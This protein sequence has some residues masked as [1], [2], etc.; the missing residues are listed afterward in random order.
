MVWPHTKPICSSRSVVEDVF[1]TW[2]ASLV[3]CLQTTN[4]MVPIQWFLS[5]Q[6]Q[7][8]WLKFVLMLLL[9]LKHPPNSFLLHLCSYV[10]WIV[11]QLAG[12]I[13]SCHVLEL[14][15]FRVF[16][17]LCPNIQL[18]TRTRN[19]GCNIYG[20]NVWKNT[21]QNSSKFQCFVILFQHSSPEQL[22][23]KANAWRTRNWRTVAQSSNMD[24]PW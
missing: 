2:A 3:S 21:T 1:K 17:V 6:N 19:K 14:L 8:K 7:S 10:W 9:T 16:W 5:Y 13:V 20:W 22:T 12:A 24:Q 15:F 18:N 11:I 23:S 4:Q